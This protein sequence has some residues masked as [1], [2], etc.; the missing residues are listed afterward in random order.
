MESGLSVCYCLSYYVLEEG[1]GRAD[2][3]GVDNGV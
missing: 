1:E 2:V 3:E